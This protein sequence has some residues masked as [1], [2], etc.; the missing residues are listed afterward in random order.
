MENSMKFKKITIF[1][2]NNGFMGFWK[3]LTLWTHFWKNQ[4]WRYG[5]F[6]ITF[7][8]NKI[9]CMDYLEN[10]KIISGKQI[11]NSCWKYLYTKPYGNV[12]VGI[13]TTN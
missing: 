4:F 1:N 2:E 9:E 10:N 13:Y 7:L 11:E 6:W 8:E 12:V 5:L 3:K